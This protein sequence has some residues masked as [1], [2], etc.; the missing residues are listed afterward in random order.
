MVKSTLGLCAAVRLV[1]SLG[2][3]VGCSDGGGATG[4]GGSGGI[5]TP[6]TTGTEG[7]MST[8]ASMNADALAVTTNGKTQPVAEP[9][10]TFLVKDGAK[11]AI[12]TQDRSPF[13]IQNNSGGELAIGAIEL[14]R[15]GDVQDGNFVY[16]DNDIK[17]NPFTAVTLKDT[18]KFDFYLRFQP[19]RS[20]ERSAD[21]KVSFTGAASGSSA[22]KYAG[23]GTDSTKCTTEPQNV[24]QFLLG[25]TTASLEDK[26]GTPVADAAGNAYITATID[27]GSSLDFM[28]FQITADGSLG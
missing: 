16:E 10:G 7:T 26:F 4:S 17:P 24:K 22:F 27:A 21:V 12:L 15:G 13:T 11:S 3:V 9:D 20:G 5:G 6:T 18:E 28:L 2:L 14:I 23:N 1:L 8:G 25:G 19:V